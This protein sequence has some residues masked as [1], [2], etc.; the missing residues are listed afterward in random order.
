MEC[1]TVHLRLAPD[2]AE[3]LISLGAIYEERR[4]VT[5]DRVLAPDRY[6]RAHLQPKRFPVKGVDWRAA[7]AHQH[8]EFI[9]I[10]KPA[11]IPVHATVDNAIE[12]ALA[13]TRAAL[14]SPLYITQRLDTDVSGLMVFARTPEFQRQFNRLL[15]KRRVEK[16][17]R[18]LVTPQVEPP[19]V[20]RYVHFMEPSPRGPKTITAEA[21]ADWLECALRVTRVAAGP[22]VTDVEIVLETGRTHQ[23]RAQLAA[24]GCPIVGDRLYGSETDFMV[25]RVPLPGIALFSAAVSWKSPEGMEWRFERTPA[26]GA[27]PLT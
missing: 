8:E 6:I 19:A 7:I 9:V 12:N 22:S 13:Q 17:Y 11:G 20:G 4:R 3:R 14:E 23:I 5:A 1:L 27:G 2:D 18:A 26:W 21:R 24:L 25:N 15:L 16:R 10:N